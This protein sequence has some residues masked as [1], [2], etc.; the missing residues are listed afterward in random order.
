MTRNSKWLKLTIVLFLVLSIAAGATD[1]PAS[2]NEEAQHII[3]IVGDGMQLEHEIAASRYLYGKDGALEFHKFPYKGFVST[4]DVTTYNRYAAAYGADLYDPEA[5]DP[6]V[7]YDPAE[8]GTRPYPTQKNH[9]NDD[10]FLTKLGTP[11]KY[12]ATDSAS[13]VTAL[14]TGFKTDDGN[15]AWLPGD[16]SNGAIK[17]IAE[18]LREIKGRSIGVVST[19][20]FSH[21]TPAGIVSHNVNRNNYAAI[22][23]E[24]IRTVQPEVVIGGGLGN[25]YISSALYNDLKAGNIPVYRF[26]E[27]QSGVDGALAI[28]G[29]ALAAAAEGKKL[30]GLFGGPGGNFE[31][32]VPTDDGS[33]VVERATI[34]NPL[35]KD[36]ALAA[37]TVLSR[38]PN[39]FFLM[40]EQGDID[41]ANHANDYNRMIGT[42]WDLNEC[43]R[44]VID[45][46]NQPGDGINWHNT[47][48]IVTSDHGNSYMRLNGDKKLGAGDLPEQNGTTYPG[49]EVTYASGDHTNELAT[50][51]AM[52]NGRFRRIFH[53][54]EGSW[55]PR[56]RIIDNT[57]LFHIMM[58]A[59]GCPVGPHLSVIESMGAPFELSA[60]GR[61]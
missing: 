8:G 41:W 45:F 55:Y 31:S 35:L 24:I 1:A 34:E 21:A 13:A 26:V 16:P 48:V 6:Y 42:M 49:G 3:L 15:I 11:A 54:Y 61:N 33:S 4:W 37:L 43:V 20:P 7:G 17:T 40:L 51:Y 56:S 18:L 2:R 52:G 28:R 36:A 22:A 12:P 39:G 44:E 50:L 30:F 9:I 59:A 32:P 46:V 14:A 23:D 47:L 60:E 38:N 25:T 29:A 53:E 19:V 58:Q 27:R 10:Y 5:I 57:Q